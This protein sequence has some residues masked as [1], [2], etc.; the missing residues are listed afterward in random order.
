MAQNEVHTLQIMTEESQKLFEQAQ[1]SIIAGEEVEGEAFAQKAKEAF[2][3]YVQAAEQG[4]LGAAYMA[5][6][7][8][9]KGA[10]GECPD[11]MAAFM[12]AAYA[13]YS[14]YV[15][16]ED[17]VLNYRAVKG[18]PDRKE[19]LAYFEKKVEEGSAVAA[20]MAGMCYELGI[21]AEM[22]P[23]KAYGLFCKSADAGN[24]DGAA[25]KALCIARGTGVARDRSAGAAMLKEISDKGNLRATLK[26]AWCLEHGW[27]VKKD[28][29]AA[30]NIYLALGD[31]KLGI[32][33]Y[34]TGRCYLDGVGVD[35]DE[36]TAY[37]W[38]LVG[39]TLG[40]VESEFGMAR[41]YLGGIVA[42]R[43]NDGFNLL[44]ACAEKGCTDAMVM[45][46]Q[47]YNKGG[48]I[49]AKDTAA[50]MDWFKKAAGMGKLSAAKAVA[51]AYTNGNG[52]KPDAQ[53]AY[54][55]NCRA[56][57]YGDTESYHN[58]GAALL[59][60][61]GVKKNEAKGF[62]YCQF[63]AEDGYMKSM[64][65]VAN[66]YAHGKGV[67]KDLKKAFELHLELA[68]KGFNK[69]QLFVGEAYYHGDNVE[70]DY[71]EAYK[72]FKLGAD[73]NN[74]FCQYYV[75]D[76]LENG[77]GV[78]ADPEA[79]VEWYKKAAEQGHVVS[80]RK[81]ESK[82]KAE[83]EEETA[84]EILADESPFET[85][86]KSAESGNAQSMYILGRYYE[87]GIGMEKNVEAAKEWYAKAAEQGNE[88]AKRALEALDKKSE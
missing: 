53:I 80:A 19:L 77:Y 75:G 30:F 17:W 39:Q 76:C 12:W 59:S 9:F 69:S 41:C 36:N 33:A 79:A 2:D 87:D 8:C 25:Q 40:S 56:A 88:A 66:C 70:K 34:E 1:A 3:L 29:E 47:L 60:G 63:A 73:K 32:G 81:I 49:V 37:S 71:N 85:F 83:A 61:T 15:P 28:R 72:W 14:H 55:Y 78:E 22:D 20:Y 38:F 10:V 51:L 42:N 62:A 45:L 16:A 86:K 23:E 27:G 21:G 82:K 4:H 84:K 26:Y 11:L 31:A 18:T 35:K 6:Q 58:A 67:K 43:Q 50:G 13:A 74:V 48:K 68:K 7:L 54:R 65:L 24:P 57:A 64:Y 5:S 44:K 46:G 52:V